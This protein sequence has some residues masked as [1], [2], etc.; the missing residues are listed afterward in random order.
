MTEAEMVAEF[1]AV[2]GV[3]VCPPGAVSKNIKFKSPN[4]EEFAGWELGGWRPGEMLYP[5]VNYHECR[6]IYDRDEWIPPIYR[7]QRPLPNGISQ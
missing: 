3:T 5:K 4:D 1:I 7:S 6:P 2:H